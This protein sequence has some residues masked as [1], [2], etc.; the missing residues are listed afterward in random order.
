MLHESTLRRL[1]I[2]RQGRAVMR[3]IERKLIP[4][5]LAYAMAALGGI[6]LGF[7]FHLL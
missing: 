4:P 5:M 2:R 7:L 1:R 3:A 6:G